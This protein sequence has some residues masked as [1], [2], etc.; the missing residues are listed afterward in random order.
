[1]SSVL[2]SSRRPPTQPLLLVPSSLACLAGSS[3]QHT[4][5]KSPLKPLTPLLLGRALTPLQALAL[6]PWVWV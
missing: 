2:K 3:R 4:L 1:M 6:A 5:T